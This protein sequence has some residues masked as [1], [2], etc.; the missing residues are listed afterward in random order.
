MIDEQKIID[1]LTSEN[2]SI[3]Q[4]DRF[5][6]EH[7]DD[8][9]F[10][11]LA[12]IIDSLTYLA[13]EAHLDSDTISEYVLY[14]NG[15]HS[16][17]MKIAPIIPQIEKHIQSCSKCRTEFEL[18]NA[19]LNEVDEFIENNIQP[20]EEEVPKQSIFLINPLK[21]KAFRY[22]FAAAASLIIMFSS[23]F[24]AS[25]I[26]TPKYVQMV[27]QFDTSNFNTTRGRNSENFS[28]AVNELEKENYKEAITLFKNDIRDNQKDITIFYTYYILGITYMQMAH[29]DFLG[30]FDS[31]DQNELAKAE[32][33]FKQAIDL[34]SS[35]LFENVKYNSYFYLGE[36]YLL[37][38]NFEQAEIFLTKAIESGS[39][40]STTAKELL[41]TIK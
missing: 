15:D 29:N 21:H 36:S 12:K 40:Y 25:N 2:L 5:R 17:E 16:E 30:M 20:S 7:K 41:S 24:I 6:K 14:L 4:I 35:G 19:E 33:S 27:N 39:E 37:Q 22:T 3:D 13:K 38:E 18:L 32:S 23:L 26:S 28:M 34:N 8:P 1:F 31:Y 11:S 9:E 10:L